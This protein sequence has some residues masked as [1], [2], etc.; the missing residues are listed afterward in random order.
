MGGDIIKG[1]DDRGVAVASTCVRPLP[2][3]P[4]EAEHFVYGVSIIISL[5]VFIV[6]LRITCNINVAGTNQAL[7]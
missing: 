7:R 3:W 5:L 6:T 4:L 1:S 2:W